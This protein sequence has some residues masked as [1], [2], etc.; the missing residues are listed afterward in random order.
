MNLF[1]QHS[2]YLNRYEWKTGGFRLRAELGATGGAQLTEIYIPAHVAGRSSPSVSGN[3]FE[4][5]VSVSGGAKL[6]SIDSQPDGSVVVFVGSFSAEGGEYVVEVAGG[7]GSSPIARTT[8]TPVGISEKNMQKVAHSLFFGTSI[9]LPAVSTSSFL[10]SG[11]PSTS[12]ADPIEA[13]LLTVAKEVATGPT[14]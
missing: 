1:L 10:S 6:Q 12:E 7:G 2:L 8:P 11:I 14:A 4:T 9:D 3:H 13:V 5:R